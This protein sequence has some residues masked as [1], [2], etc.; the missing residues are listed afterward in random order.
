MQLSCGPAARHPSSAA[1]NLLM[2]PIRTLIDLQGASPSPLL[3]DELRILYGGDL[4]F[5]VFSGERPYVVGNFVST[6][7]GVISFAVPGQ[8]GGGTIQRF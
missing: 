2:E 5:P 1:L 6:L 4:R 7:D 8:S 3:P